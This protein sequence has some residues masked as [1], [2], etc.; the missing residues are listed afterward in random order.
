MQ[1]RRA[2]RWTPLS[3]STRLSARR[4]IGRRDLRDTDLRTVTGGW[5]EENV[6][7]ATRALSGSACAALIFGLMATVAQ[8]YTV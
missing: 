2:V 1:N 8:A 3:G 5:K 7:R 6:T 4:R